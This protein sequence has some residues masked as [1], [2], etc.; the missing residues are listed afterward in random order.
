MSASLLFGQAF[1]HLFNS[2]GNLLAAG[3]VLECDG[4]V[5]NFVST[6]DSHEGDLT[7]VGIVHLLFHLCTVRIQLCANA[8]ATQCHDMAQGCRSLLFAEV[9]EHHP[10]RRHGVGRIQIES[11][12][13][14]VDAVGTEADSVHRQ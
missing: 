14:V 12:E 11:V 9:D 13:H 3:H 4:A 10:C 8:S 2:E 7:V 1:Y 6:D 5:L